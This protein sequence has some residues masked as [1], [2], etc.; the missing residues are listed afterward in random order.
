MNKTKKN[1]FTLIELI[2]AITIIAVVTAVGAV[3]YNGINKKS[4]DSRRMADLE[5]YRIALEIA[6]QV[7]S[8]YPSSLSTLVTMNLLP[9]TMVDPKTASAYVFSRTN[10]TYTLTATMEDAGSTNVPGVYQVT[11]P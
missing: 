5:K 7:G 10:Y 3:S 4:R 8:T 6:K 9:G 1:G 2:V 11:N